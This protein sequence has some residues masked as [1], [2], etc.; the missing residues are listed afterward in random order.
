MWF[1]KKR[2]QIIQ[3]IPGNACW[4]ALVHQHNID[5]DTLS[6]KMRCVIKEDTLNGQSITRVRIFDIRKIEENGILI[7]GWETFDQH[8]EALAFEGYFNQSN[9]AFIERNNG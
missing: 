9:E 3:R 6:N 7:T 5:V 4:G 1:W 8:P 2:E